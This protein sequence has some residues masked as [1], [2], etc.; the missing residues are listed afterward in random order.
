MVFFAPSSGEGEIARIDGCGVVDLA[1][2]FSSSMTSSG[3]SFG[4][5]S[6]SSTWP[7]PGAKYLKAPDARLEAR[8]VADLDHAV[9]GAELGL[10]AEPCRD[11]LALV[12]GDAG[13]EFL[14]VAVARHR[15]RAS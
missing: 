8:G 12:H 14:E 1:L 11:H 10:D 9:E 13:V 4:A 3:S 6:S 15:L 5:N 7:T 2:R